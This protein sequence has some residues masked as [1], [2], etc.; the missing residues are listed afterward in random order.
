MLTLILILKR[1]LFIVVAKFGYITRGY[2]LVGKT[3]ILHISIPGSIPGTSICV[4]VLAI[5]FFG[6]FPY[7]TRG[8]VGK[9][10]IFPNRRH[11]RTHPASLVVFLGAY[12]RA[13][14]CEASRVRAQTSFSVRP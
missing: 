6:L 7:I 3:L 8:L 1:K 2:S 13:Y 5:Y 14:G 11:A 10:L 9:M 4:S 12:V